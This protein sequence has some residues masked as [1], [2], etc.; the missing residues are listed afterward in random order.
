MQGKLLVCVA[1]LKRMPEFRKAVKQSGSRCRSAI[2]VNWD[3][4]GS[5]SLIL[6]LDGPLLP[7]V[8]EACV[9]PTLSLD[10]FIQLLKAR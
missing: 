5:R 9:I 10:D 6:K 2:R 8:T 7:K 3:H 1:N 4:D